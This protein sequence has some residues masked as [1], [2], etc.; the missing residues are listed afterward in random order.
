M[1]I[2]TVDV[3]T[4]HVRGQNAHPAPKRRVYVWV[5]KVGCIPR[6]LAVACGSLLVGAY[7]SAQRS[8][9]TSKLRGPWTL[10]PESD[11]CICRLVMGETRVAAPRRVFFLLLLRMDDEHGWVLQV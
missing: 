9:A 11:A 1:E 10:D 2:L 7:G 4:V 8:R 6:P 3:R 5:C